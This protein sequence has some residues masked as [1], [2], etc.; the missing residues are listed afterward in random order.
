MKPIKLSVVLLLILFAGSNLGA[1]KLY[2]WTDEKGVLHIT[3]N[4]PPKRAR[5]K[6]VTKYR[7][8]TPQEIDAIQREKEDLRRK[9]EKEEQIE[10]ARKSELQA[11]EADQR[12]N[13]AV[14]QA[15]E[16]YEHNLE[17]IKRLSTTRDKRKQFRKKIQ[18]L[19]DESEAAQTEAQMAAKQ[20]QEAAQK[21]RM[22]A[23]EAE[24]PIE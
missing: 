19:K 11:R 20:A 12:A 13:E 10:R 24:K 16:K 18:R 6:D 23:E 7:E 9:Y 14:K 8:K 22:T 4:P 21:A 2:T 5:I 1:Q 3:D 15:Q 17:Y